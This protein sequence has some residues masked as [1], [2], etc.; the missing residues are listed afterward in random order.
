ML[1]G[2]GFSSLVVDRYTVLD[3]MDQDIELNVIGF[4]ALGFHLN[5]PGQ[6]FSL[7]EYRCDPIAHVIIGF[8]QIVGHFIFI[9]DHV[10]LVQL[11]RAGKQIFPVI[12]FTGHLKAYQ[13]RSIIE[14]NIIFKL[15]LIP[16]GG[17]DV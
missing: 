12:I 7:S 10:N 1:I 2:C 4:N 14:P 17:I 13:M 8:S 11:L 9:L 6:Q 5:C 15:F 16:T 3:I